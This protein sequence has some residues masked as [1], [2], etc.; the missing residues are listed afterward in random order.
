MADR[1]KNFINNNLTVCEEDCEFTS[2]DN[3]LGKA[4]CSCNVKTSANTKI[5]DVKIDKDKLFKSFIDFKNIGN[6]KVLKCYKAIFKL[7]ALKHNYANIIFIIII[8]FFFFVLIYFYCKDF[9]YLKK[10]M[11]VIE[12]FKLNPKVEKDFLNKEKNNRKIKQKK[13]AKI[14]SNNINNDEN[15]SNPIKRIKK[16]KSIL[17]NFEINNISSGQKVLTKK[18]KINKNN[19]YMIK[20]NKKNK[21]KKY[22]NNNNNLITFP[23]TSKSKDKK[24]K[25]PNN[26]NEKQMYKMCLNI[27]TFTDSEKNDFDYEKALLFDRRTFCLYYVSLIRTKHLIFFSFRHAF[28]YNSQIIKIFLFFFEFASSFFVNALFFNDETMH[29]I[30]E[31]RVLLISYI[32]YLK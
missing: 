12:Y 13:K 11:N 6:I 29:K 16:P 18:I 19:D 9:P 25:F 28:D 24:N 8:L 30:Y 14:K 15:K 23:Q 27:N 3:V 4:Q 2:Y 21:N 10:I 26:L 7:D 1:K 31:E 32:I 5:G 20:V 17:N 22:V